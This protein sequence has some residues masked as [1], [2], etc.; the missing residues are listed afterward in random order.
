MS[1]PSSHSPGDGVGSDADP[2]GESPTE[3]DDFRE[4]LRELKA[5]GCNLL[6]VGDAPRHLFTCASA[7]LLGDPEERRYRL[8]AVTDASPRSV[9]ERL[10]DPDEAP[11]PLGETT[12]IVNHASPPRSVTDDAGSS[13]ADLPG[14]AETHVVDPQLAGLQ[15]QLTEGM[16]A[17]NQ[18]AGGLRPGE[19]RVGVDSLESLFGH[20]DDGVVRRCLRV[21]TGYVADYAGMGHYVLPRPYDSER[22]E[23]LAPEF[24]AVVEIRAVDPATCDHDA[25]ERW[26]VPSRELTTDWMPM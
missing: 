18:L 3:T 5:E 6:V 2:V 15:A 22:V 7:G 24:D 8:L 14:I 26:H 25:E 9:A 17:F 19:L 10:P 16:A 4:V 1:S 12:R 21:V 11:E 20:Y 13:P 23:S